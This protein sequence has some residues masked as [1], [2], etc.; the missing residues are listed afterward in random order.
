MEPIIWQKAA[1]HGLSTTTIHTT[2]HTTIHTVHTLSETRSDPD[3][4]I[5]RERGRNPTFLLPSLAPPP[6]PLL[7]HRASASRPNTS[8][9]AAKQP[10]R[11]GRLY[12]RR[13]RA[14]LHACVLA[15]RSVELA[16]P[17]RCV[18]YGVRRLCSTQPTAL[19]QPEPRRHRRDPRMAVVHLALQGG[20][21]RFIFSSRLST[22]ETAQI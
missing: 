8:A 1:T 20:I 14:S 11:H 18:T 17:R 15:R 21:H 9:T 19:R 12:R 10:Q 16:G 5:N 4:F 7:F 13:A 6:P 22:S 3:I 2:T